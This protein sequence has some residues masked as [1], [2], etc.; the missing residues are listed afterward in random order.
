MD[1]EEISKLSADLNY[2]DKLRL[3]QLLI[4][5]AR[6]EEEAKNPKARETLASS[7]RHANES[8]EYVA[9]RLLKL[10]PT[11]RSSLANSIGAMFQFRGGISDTD[12]EEI[13]LALERSGY[14]AIDQDNRVSYPG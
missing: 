3:A 13:I 1:F 5:Q 7:D 12:K 4:Q 2:R 8:I 10:K 6:K 14:I 11:K 9:D